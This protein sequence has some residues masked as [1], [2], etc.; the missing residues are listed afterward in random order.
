MLQTETAPALPQTPVRAICRA[1]WQPSIFCTVSANRYLS[2]RRSDAQRRRALAAFTLATV[3]HYTI[4]DCFQ[5]GAAAYYAAP[6]TRTPLYSPFG[7]MVL[8][9][10]QRLRRWSYYDAPTPAPALPNQPLDGCHCHACV[11]RW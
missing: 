9:A 5:N 2:A 1:D 8:D 7:A 3:R 6:A 4:V 10:C 11:L